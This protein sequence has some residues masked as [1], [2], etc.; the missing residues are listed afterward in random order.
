MT[1]PEE[2]RPIIC[3]T[4]YGTIE[5]GIQPTDEKRSDEP[6][7]GDLESRSSSVPSVL[8]FIVSMI[9]VG[10]LSMV[11]VNDKTIYTNTDVSLGE[12][13]QKPNFIVIV[14]DDLSWN[15]IGYTE[16]KYE[17]I[18]P[19]L[20]SLAR[21]GVIMDNFYA[22]E[23]CSPARASLLTGR[24]PLSI[25]MQYG[26]V[27][28]TAEWGMDLDEMTIAEILSDHGYATHMLGKS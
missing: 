20:T 24:Y 19:T 16:P 1:I 2:E 10:A 23:V 14:A 11:A 6:A 5:Q 25:G 7:T 21:S 8:G 27:A 22:Q 15:S 28:A 4:N 3:S 17:V 13:G 26:M 9:F 12:V 18:T